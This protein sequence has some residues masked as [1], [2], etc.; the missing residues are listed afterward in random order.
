[1]SQKLYKTGIFIPLRV[2]TDFTSSHVKLF[3]W[4]LQYAYNWRNC[5]KGDVDIFIAESDKR[6][7][8]NNLNFFFTIAIDCIFPKIPFPSSGQLILLT[9]QKAQIVWFAFKRITLL[10]KAVGHIHEPLYNC[11]LYRRIKTPTDC[12]DFPLFT[13]SNFKTNK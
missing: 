13:D 12:L 6:I 3:A 8:K 4:N 5:W 1:M 2:L 9:R 11:K 7:A 10:W